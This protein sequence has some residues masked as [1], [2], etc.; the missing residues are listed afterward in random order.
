MATADEAN[1]DSGADEDDDGDDCDVGADCDDGD[2]DAASMM[3]DDRL[4]IIIVRLAMIL[5]SLDGGTMLPIDRFSS[6]LPIVLCPGRARY[7]Y[8]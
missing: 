1:T 2:G 5:I 3:G 8:G 4:M 6:R 7:E